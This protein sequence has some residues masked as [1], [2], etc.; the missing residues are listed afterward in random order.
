V[1]KSTL[2]RFYFDFKK[3]QKNLTQ[4][5]SAYTPAVSLV[6][7]LAESLKKI[8][9]EGLNNIFARHARLAKATRE[10]MLALGLT[11]YAPQA[12]SNAVTAVVAPPGV[13]GQKVVKILRDK[14]HLTIAGGQDQAKG[15]IFRIAHL[16]Y[17]DKFD[18]LMAVAAVEMTLKELGYGVEMGKGV[19][20]AME[21]L[22]QER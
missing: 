16:G 21:V 7:G 8:K 9:E 18:I 20:A 2:P 22:I 10:A 4:N 13:D 11:L 5:Q 12:Y 1:A 17:V 19:R 3:E 15:K 6:M 14:H